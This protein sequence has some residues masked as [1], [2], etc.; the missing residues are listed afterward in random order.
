MTEAPPWRQVLLVAAALETGLLPA[1]RDP[2]TPAQRAGEL[3]LDVRAVGIVSRA[4]ADAGLLTT[5]GRGGY[6]L[7]EAGRELTAERPSGAPDPAAG[8]LLEARSIASHLEIQ[9]DPP[10]P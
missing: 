4:L 1:Y 5:A 2:G 9:S 10:T 6:E 8:L 3:G 7:S